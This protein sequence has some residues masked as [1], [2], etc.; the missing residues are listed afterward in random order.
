[1]KKVLLGLYSSLISLNQTVIEY[2]N[3]LK[4]APSFRC[5]NQKPM[6]DG[7]KGNALSICRNKA[8]LQLTI[9]A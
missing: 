3:T 7:G 2:G 4:R 9:H 1:M 6:I 8:I 5:P